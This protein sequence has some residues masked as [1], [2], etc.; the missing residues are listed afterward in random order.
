[1]KQAHAS[2][3][4]IAAAALPLVLGTYAVFVVS[5]QYA[6]L[7]LVGSY[8]AFQGGSNVGNVVSF[9]VW[10]GLSALTCLVLVHLVRRREPLNF[11]KAAALV[12]A[13]YGVPAVLSLL[14]DTAMGFAVSHVR[15][16]TDETVL[17][18]G[19]ATFLVVSGAASLAA[20]AVL[21]GV[22]MFQASR[23]A[24]RWTGIPQP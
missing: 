13:A 11:A 6:G 8:R 23:R 10:W 16:F 15:A 12:L 4:A 7:G 21:F 5:A 9:V 1:M 19:I 20:A 14:P 17:H 22:G 24:A 2:R 18:S 3:A